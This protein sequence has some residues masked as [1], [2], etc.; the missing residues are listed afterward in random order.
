MLGEIHTADVVLNTS[1][2]ALL[3]NKYINFHIGGFGG[4]VVEG[5]G[6][7]LMFYCHGYHTFKFCMCYNTF[8]GVDRYLEVGGGGTCECSDAPMIDFWERLKRFS[9]PREE[10]KGVG[11]P[12]PVLNSVNSTLCWILIWPQFIYVFIYLFIY[13]FVLK[14]ESADPGRPPPPPFCCIVRVQSLENHRT[15]MQP[16]PLLLIISRVL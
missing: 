7:L 1:C 16:P 2:F 4:G 6:Y 15:C 11:R 5:W 3:Y 9:F 8:K 12:Y 13:L 14:K 10:V